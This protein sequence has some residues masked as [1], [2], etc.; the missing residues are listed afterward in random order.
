MEKGKSLFD[1]NF[2]QEVEY[3]EQEP[4]TL[5]YNNETQI[6][7]LSENY[8]Q[9]NWFTPTAMSM[10]T[11]CNKIFQ[12]IISAWNTK[13]LNRLPITE[14]CWDPDKI[15]L[16]DLELVIKTSDLFRSIGNVSFQDTFDEK[17]KLSV[18]YQLFDKALN[19]FNSVAHFSLTNKLKLQDPELYDAVKKIALA[20]QTS[21]EDIDYSNIPMFSIARKDNILTFKVNEV[22]VPVFDSITS[23]FTNLSLSSI[24]DLKGNSLRI[25][26]YFKQRLG[27]DEKFDFIMYFNPTPE[28]PNDNMRF[29][30]NQLELNELGQYASSTNREDK[31]FTRTFIPNVDEINSICKDLYIEYKDEAGNIDSNR[32]IKKSRKRIGFKFTLYAKNPNVAHEPAEQETYYNKLKKLYPKA[33]ILKE[34]DNEYAFKAIYNILEGTNF[35]NKH[36]DA[37]LMTNA[38]WHKLKELYLNSCYEYMQAIYYNYDLEKLDCNPYKIMNTFLSHGSDIYD[39]VRFLK[40]HILTWTPDEEY[41]KYG[42]K[43]KHYT[44]DELI[45]ISKKPSEPISPMLLSFLE[46]IK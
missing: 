23:Y 36:Y 1:I 40:Q 5:S 38:S 44:K 13:Y 19:Q 27:I 18:N 3:Q 12:G 39:G 16:M 35:K 6:T 29:I 41:K 22:M 8:R 7:I 11:Y 43:L 20:T 30:L 34:W 9:S 4:V 33:K 14:S 10:D 15:K 2:E 28:N 17:G 26:E 42:I 31:L 24:K 37:L 25:Y 32:Y 21:L 46:K 45:E